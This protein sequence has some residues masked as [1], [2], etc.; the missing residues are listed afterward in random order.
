MIEIKLNDPTDMVNILVQGKGT[1][2]SG[3]ELLNALALY[4]ETKKELEDGD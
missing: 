4:F 1:V 2:I 3:D